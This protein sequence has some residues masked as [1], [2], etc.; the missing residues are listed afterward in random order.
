MFIHEKSKHLT[1]LI[2]H[3]IGLEQPFPKLFSLNKITE[4]M[5]IGKIPLSIHMDLSKAF[6]TLDHS[7]LLS[8][9]AYYGIGRDMCNNLLKSYLTDRYQYVEYKS[10]R[11]P[12][13]SII[14][15]VP[16]GSILGPLLFLIY[17]NDLPMVSQIFDMIMYADDTTLY[18]NINRDISDQDI[19]AELKKVSDWL[20]SNKLSLN[21]KKTKCMVFHT[22]QRKVAY[23]I[24][25]LN[26]IEIERVTQLIS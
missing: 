22:A 15:G 23:P 26:N 4:Q 25:T 20:C 12:T 14:T 21:V 17:I 6:D 16:Q 8:K 13:K 2:A 11:S 10:A 18:C 24:L 7:I 3:F 5:D 19:N 9:L 1:Y